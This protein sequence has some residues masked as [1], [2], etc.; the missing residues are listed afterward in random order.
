ML[1]SSYLDD[2]GGLSADRALVRLD[3]RG[4]GGSAVPADKATYRCDHQVADVEA[5]RVALGLDRVDLLAHSAGAA[6]AV[7]YAAR[8]PARV[9]RL[10]LVNPSPRVVGLEI[11]D[12]DRRE[13]A[14]RRRGESWFPAAFAAFERVWSGRATGEDWAAI[15]PFRHGR[16]DAATAAR[17]ADEDG[18]RNDEAAAAYYADGR[19]DPGEVRAALAGV[20]ARALVTTGEH[21][22]S[23]PPRAAAAYAGLFGR[24]EVAVQ[25]GGGH[26]P[27]RDDPAWLRRTVSGFLADRT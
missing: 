7:L 8:H 16:W 4:T 27:W 26:S 1:P 14:E 19:P 13:V 21:D 24:G 9:D 23:L 2:L 3:L 12:A 17:V 5:L 11:T 25:P 10:V 20:A 6:I 22:V 15:E 18:Q